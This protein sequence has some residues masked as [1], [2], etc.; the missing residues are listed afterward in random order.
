MD[1]YTRNLISV[2]A[3]RIKDDLKSKDGTVSILYGEPLDLDDP[4]SVLV[5]AVCKIEAEMRQENLENLK[6]FMTKQ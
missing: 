2:M 1:N 4:D 6:I 5:A 3:K